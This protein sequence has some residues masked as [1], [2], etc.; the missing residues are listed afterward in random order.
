MG[1]KLRTR[2]P[3]YPD[4]L[5]PKTTD[6]DHLRKKER[7]YR[8]TVKFNYD[9][10]HRVVDGEQLSPGDRVWIADLKAEGT[11]MEEHVAP[12][13][14]VIQSPNGQVRRNRRMTRR[15]LGGSPPVVSHSASREILEP[16]A[17]RVTMPNITSASRASQKAPRNP[18][19]RTVKTR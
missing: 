5:K 2:V 9:R 17:T 8:T 12:R 14:V 16:L 6:Y 1:R 10:R 15:V 18:L 4:E 3:C 13:S 19:V 11:V 7:E